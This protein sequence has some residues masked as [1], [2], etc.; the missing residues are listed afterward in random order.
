MNKYSKTKEKCITASWTENFFSSRNGAHPT[1]STDPPHF[2]CLAGHSSAALWTPQEVRHSKEPHSHRV[3]DA[4][5]TIQT[6]KNH[7]ILGFVRQVR[8]P[9]FTVGLSD[10]TGTRLA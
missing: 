3:N 2:G 5:K 7:L 9:L 4:E 10:P 6:F 1:D 8:I